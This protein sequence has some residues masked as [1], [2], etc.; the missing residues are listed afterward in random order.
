MINNRYPK[1]SVKCPLACG[2]VNKRYIWPSYHINVCIPKPMSYLTFSEYTH[3]F[4]KSGHTAIMSHI[5]S[6][7]NDTT[8]NLA[9]KVCL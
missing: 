8:D 1:M 9:S 5:Y 3:I 2:S 4:C 6:K 7:F